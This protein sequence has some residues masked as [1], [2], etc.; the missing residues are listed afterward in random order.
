MFHFVFA[1][2]FI[3]TNLNIAYFSSHSIVC[4]CG[5]HLC[6]ALEN[7]YAIAMSGNISKSFCKWRFLPPS[8]PLRHLSRCCHHHILHLYVSSPS[9]SSLSSMPSLSSSSNVNILI[10]SYFFYNCTSVQCESHFRCH[11][12][13]LL[14]CTFIYIG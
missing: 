11:H 12:F 2:Q 10:T 1:K 3:K 9:Q 7:R 5:E 8:L 6:Y 13:L 4:M 14:C